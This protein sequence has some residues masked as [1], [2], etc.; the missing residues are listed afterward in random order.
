MP[1]HREQN[2]DEEYDDDC[3]PKIIRDNHDQPPCII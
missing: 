1:R 3:D 2:Q